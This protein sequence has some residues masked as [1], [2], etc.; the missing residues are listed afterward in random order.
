M[1]EKVRLREKICYGSGGVSYAVEMAVVN[2]F[3]LLFFTDVMKVSAAAISIMFLVC[4]VLDAVTDIA[5]VNIADNMN[6]RFGRYRVWLL[7][8]IPL[9]ITFV[10]LFWYPGFLDSNI[11]KIIY[12]YI[13]YIIT[14]PICETSYMC[15]LY[16]MA[17]T[18]S[19]EEKDRVGFVTARCTG[20]TMGDVVAASVAMPIILG[21][22]TSYRD[23]SG[24]RVMALIIGG[25]IILCGVISFL[26]TRERVVSSN[27]DENGNAITLRAKARTLRGNK[28]FWRLFLFQTGYDVESMAPI[29]LFSYYC[30]YF[31][32][33]PEW[34]GSLLI[35]VSA[36]QIL[37]IALSG[38]ILQEIEKR[39]LINTA[40]AIVVAGWIVLLMAKSYWMLALYN[41]MR[42]FAN[43]LFIVCL[44][45]S[46]PNVSDHTELNYSDASPGFIMSVA[47]CGNKIGIGIA[48][49]MITVALSIIGYNGNA[50]VQSPGTIAGFRIAMILLPMAG[51]LLMIFMNRGLSVLDRSSIESVNREL[52]EKRNGSF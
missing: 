52:S 4:K 33:H 5:V 24:W 36:G 19:T 10:M 26:G 48:S 35:F 42:G 25:V 50:A 39:S 14:I 18:M 43:G 12:C 2:S 17:A 44:G 47:Q 37:A 34:V 51:L 3:L 45:S 40:C 6:S 38:R 46:W 31:V 27:K 23:V 13:A 16:V 28:P 21:F 32:G 30:I 8:S 22:G 7:M 20:D 11:E 41:V 29:M 9:G 15:P 49:Y 1:K